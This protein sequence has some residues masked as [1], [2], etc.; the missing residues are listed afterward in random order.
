[1]EKCV[2]FS[3]VSNF[4]VSRNSLMAIEMKILAQID[5]FD[6][7]FNQILNFITK[8]CLK[9]DKKYNRKILLCLN[10]NQFYNFLL[11]CLY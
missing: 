11:R 5:S 7:P 1:M 2:N 10:K 9:T 6:L 3:P 4:N 8:T